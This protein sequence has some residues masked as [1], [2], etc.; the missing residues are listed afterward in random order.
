MSILGTRNHWQSSG[1]LGD[2]ERGHHTTDTGYWHPPAH[3]CSGPGHRR[4]SHAHHKPCIDIV[5]T[6]RVYNFKMSQQLR[7]PSMLKAT[8]FSV[9]ISYSALCLRGM[10]L[11]IWKKL[12]PLLDLTSDLAFKGSWELQWHCRD[13]II[14]PVRTL[15]TFMM[16]LFRIDIQWYQVFCFH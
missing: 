2:S 3:Q 4:L 5:N 1:L 12:L 15:K 11:S 9:L 6:T 14:A 7:Q 16:H 8:V 13:V 10:Q